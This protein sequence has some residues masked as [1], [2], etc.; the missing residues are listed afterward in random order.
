MISVTSASRYITSASRYHLR[1]QSRCLVYIRG[2]IPRNF[3]EFAEAVP[4][5]LFVFRFVLSS[6]PRQEQIYGR[7]L[8]RTFFYGVIGS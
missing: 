6:V 5:G 8:Q 1:Y 2:L 4:V 7:L 3:A